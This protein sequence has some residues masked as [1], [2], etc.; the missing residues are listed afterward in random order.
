L[1]DLLISA[2]PLESDVDSMAND[3]LMIWFESY[4]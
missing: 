1:F 3:A 2:V 4:R